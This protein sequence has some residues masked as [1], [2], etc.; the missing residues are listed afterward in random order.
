VARGAG[1][2]WHRRYR[3]VKGQVTGARG[4]R[5]LGD[6][7]ERDGTADDGLRRAGEVIGFAVLARQSFD[8]GDGDWSSA[9]E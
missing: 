4:R 8:H 3:A 9:G 7:S 6:A 2:R 1:R 5:R